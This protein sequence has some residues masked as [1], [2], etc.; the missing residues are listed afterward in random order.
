MNASAHAYFKGAVA[1]VYEKSMKRKSNHEQ[2]TVNIHRRRVMQGVGAAAVATVAGPVISQTSS[3]F[4]TGDITGKIV[5]KLDNPVKSV[6]L[7]N[8]TPNAVTISHFDNGS[9]IFDGEFVDCNG[10]CENGSVTLASGD[11]KLFQFDKREFFKSNSRAKSWV[12]L[13]AN[14]TRMSEGTRVVDI[15]GKVKNGVVTFESHAA[16]LF[17]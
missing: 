16:P 8:N 1:P 7:K 12:N 5:S 11:E 6:I 9:V 3:T 2:N 17:S 15:A 10:L 13:Q 14:V 4:V